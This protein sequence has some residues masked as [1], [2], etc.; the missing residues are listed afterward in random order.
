MTA[1][2]DLPHASRCQHSDVGSNS[3]GKLANTNSLLLTIVDGVVSHVTAGE[4][5][6]RESVCSVAVKLLVTDARMRRTHLSANQKS[7]S[8]ARR[9]VI[10]PWAD[11]GVYNADS[12]VPTAELGTTRKNHLSDE[13]HQP[14]TAVGLARLCS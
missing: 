9:C 3:A 11:Q 6:T 13:R 1:H 5:V 14:Q 8:E 7:D 10:E 12:L 2:L 4:L